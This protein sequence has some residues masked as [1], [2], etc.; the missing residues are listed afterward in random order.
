MLVEEEFSFPIPKRS[1]SNSPKDSDVAV[2]VRTLVVL[3][4]SWEVPSKSPRIAQS[5]SGD[6]VMLGTAADEVEV[7]LDGTRPDDPYK[8]F[9]IS[10]NELPDVVGLAVEEV[11]GVDA[12]KV[13]VGEEVVP[14]VVETGTA[15][16]VAS[17]PPPRAP[18]IAST[19]RTAPSFTV[20]ESSPKVDVGYSMTSEVKSLF[21]NS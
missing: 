20:A 7:E 21:P 2:E 9:K 16:S 1:S 18:K 19:F 3:L 13:V 17:D 6:E 5:S 15:V 4:A 10:S 12:T 11:F 14:T 8:E